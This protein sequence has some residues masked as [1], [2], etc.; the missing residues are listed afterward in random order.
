M[1]LNKTDLVTG[2]DLDRIEA[3]LR[4]MNNFAPIQRCCM[5]EV[6]VDSVLNIR[7]F[8]LKRTLEMDPEFLNSDGEH[9]HDQNVSSLSIV[10]QGD[11][12]LDYMNE[13]VGWVLRS[14]AID[15]YRMKG[16]LAIAN[17]EQKYVYQAV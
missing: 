11:L 17:A 9:Q 13:W 4:A 1:L 6:S 3:R 15:I 14:Q 8:D 7:G 2:A 5:G 12:N 16:V 10:Q